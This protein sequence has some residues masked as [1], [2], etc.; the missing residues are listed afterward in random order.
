MQAD[1]LKNL[2]MLADPIFLVSEIATSSGGR[3]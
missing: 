1:M 3:A 2:P